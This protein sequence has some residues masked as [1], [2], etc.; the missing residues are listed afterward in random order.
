LTFGSEDSKDA[1]VIP[2]A[3]FKDIYM[4]C[5][6]VMALEPAARLQRE[7]A[8]RALAMLANE[9]D[10][11][12]FA[13][14]ISHILSSMDFRAFNYF[15]EASP[16][17]VAHQLALGHSGCKS[18]IGKHVGMGY[19][20][21]ALMPGKVPVKHCVLIERKHVKV[22][23]LT[24]N[25][26]NSAWEDALLKLRKCAGDKEFE[27][28]DKQG[29]LKKWIVALTANRCIANHEIVLDKPNAALELQPDTSLS[30]IMDEMNRIMRKNAFRECFEGVFHCVA[31]FLRAAHCK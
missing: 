13:Q 3:V 8:S 15:G 1:L 20:D 7:E 11:R 5:F 24:L 12:L 26:I 31:P 27:R 19:A 29:G 18:A 22:K 9:G 16:A 25:N 21:R 6:S 2:N 30:K 14:C 4:N 10:T 17:R 28:L 23:K